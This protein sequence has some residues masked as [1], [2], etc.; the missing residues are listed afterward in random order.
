MIVIVI[1][2]H[3]KSLG[4]DGIIYDRI[5]VNSVKEVKQS[6][7]MMEK[8]EEEEEEEHQKSPSQCSCNSPPRDPNVSNIRI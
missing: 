8:E 1:F 2:Q 3:L 5:D 7:F 6:I 4:V